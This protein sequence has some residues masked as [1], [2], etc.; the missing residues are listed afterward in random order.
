MCSRKHQQMLP[1]P[2]QAGSSK[3]SWQLC[4]ERQACRN[5][6]RA[7]QVQPQHLTRY[8]GWNVRWGQGEHPDFPKPTDPTLTSPVLCCSTGHCTSNTAGDAKQPDCFFPFRVEGLFAVQHFT[9]WTPRLGDGVWIRAS[10]KAGGA[11]ECPLTQ[12]NTR[13]AVTVTGGRGT[14]RTQR[15][16]TSLR[17]LGAGAK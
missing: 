12:C 2:K 1:S 5:L 10:S 11:P 15:S 13:L 3:S 17:S 14:E 4:A 7:A 6:W 16:Y 8:Q 9:G